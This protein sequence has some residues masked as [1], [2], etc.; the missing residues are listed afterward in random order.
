[1]L[2][3]EK[4]ASKNHYDVG[5]NG[6]SERDFKPK[7]RLKRKRAA[8]RWYQLARGTSAMADWIEE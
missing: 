5:G 7:N 8:L 6:E 2:S 3:T 1:M 4:I